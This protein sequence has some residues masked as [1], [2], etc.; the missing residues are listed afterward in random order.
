V[1]P[2]TVQVGNFRGSYTHSQPCAKWL[3]LVSL[4]LKK[5][6]AGQSV[7]CNHTTKEVMQGW[8]K[9]LTIGVAWEFTGK[10]KGAAG[11]GGS[12]A[13]PIFFLLKNG[14]ILRGAELERG[15]WKIWIFSKAI[16]W[17]CRD[18]KKWKTCFLRDAE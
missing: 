17:W 13:T 5:F 1:G 12:N 4:Q 14:T 16:F 15:K 7:S 11:E 18:R 6:L 8:L 2:Q 3:S 10:G 9:G